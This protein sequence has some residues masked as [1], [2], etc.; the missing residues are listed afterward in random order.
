MTAASIASGAPSPT[1][2]PSISFR[3][4]KCGARVHWPDDAT[5]DLKLTCENCGDDLGTYGDLRNQGMGAARTEVERLFK[6]AF[7]R[8]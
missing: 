4:E 5:D 3:C 2:G 8:R 7:K 1:R 6:E